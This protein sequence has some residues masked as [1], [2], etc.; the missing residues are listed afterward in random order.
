MGKPNTRRVDREILLVQRKIE[1]V[2]RQEWWPLTGSERR[3]IMAALAGGSLKVAR[4]KS[5]ARAE[6]KLEM[7]TQSVMNRLTAEL[8]ALQN[9][10]QRIANDFATAKAAKKSS[11]WW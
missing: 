5:P 1:A 8:T 3:Q 10:R 11:S 4:G 7:L 2:R 6:R 9:E